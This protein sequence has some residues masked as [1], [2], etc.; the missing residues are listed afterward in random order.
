MKIFSA[1]TITER[2][3]RAATNLDLVL[4]DD[5]FCYIFSGEP[6]QKPGGLD[7]TYPFLPHP[8]YYWISGL[9]RPMG[10]VV[11]SKSEGWKDFVK[12]LSLEER[13]W[14][15]GT[16]EIP[17]TPL[18]ELDAWRAKKKAARCIVLGQATEKFRAWKNTDEATHN[19]IQE[20]FNRARRKKDPE[21]IALITDA[22]RA[23]AV[24]YSHLKKFIR[25][26]VSERQI[27]IEF[28]TAALKAG[29]EKFPYDTIVGSGVNAAVLHAIPTAKIVQKGELVLIDAG[30]DIHD[31]C[32]DITRVFFAD[33]TPSEQQSAI[34]SIVAKAQ[35]QAIQNCIPGKEWV[36]VHRSA[37]R[38]IAEGLKDLKIFAGSVDSA[39]ESEAISVFFP[40]GIGHMVGHRVRDV[41]PIVGKAP[42]THFG[43]RLRVDLAL[44]EDFVMTAEPGIYFVSALIDKKENR[45]RFKKEIHWNEV[46]K[47]RHFGGIRLEDDILVKENP[48]NLTHSIEK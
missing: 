8:D 22:A 40:H 13:L 38:V 1:D 9:R 25:P 36:E 26:G 28:E 33:G 18:A 35:Q 19:R 43:V 3:K 47:W 2:R 7:Q 45:E 31:Y 24:G 17:G 4:T 21:E 15:G 48:V 16:E 5:E 23:A 32:V 34:Y 6:I 14:E 46:E 30:A 20:A 27:Q 37:A 44:E 12:P 42:K 11:Y 10:V 41:G 29:A 39:L